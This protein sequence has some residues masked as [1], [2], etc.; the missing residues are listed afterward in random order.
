MKNLCVYSSIGVPFFWQILLL[1]RSTE[2]LF[3]IFGGK[4]QQKSFEVLTAWWNTVVGMVCFP[5]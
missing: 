1:A 5:F 4:A 2:K 3:V